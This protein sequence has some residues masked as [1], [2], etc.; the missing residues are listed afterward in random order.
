[1]KA[2]DEAIVWLQTRRDNAFSVWNNA[3]NHM[4]GV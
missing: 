2:I 3:S 4:V 1:M